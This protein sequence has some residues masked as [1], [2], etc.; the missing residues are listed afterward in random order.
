M[1]TSNP[2]LG[3]GTNIL[4]T[5]GSIDAGASFLPSSEEPSRRILVINL[6]P[7]HKHAIVSKPL[8]GTLG[9]LSLSLGWLRAQRGIWL[10]ASARRSV[11]SQ[12]ALSAGSTLHDGLTGKFG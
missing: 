7:S 8:F 2:F 1:N 6:N 12:L 5:L 11:P 9:V 4:S 3:P 10:F